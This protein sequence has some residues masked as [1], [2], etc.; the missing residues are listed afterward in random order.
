MFGKTST[1][2][3]AALVI[4]ASGCAQQSQ[5]RAA[6]DAEQTSIRCP[7]GQTLQCETRRIGRIRHGT[8]GASNENCACMPEGMATLETP[9]IP[10]IH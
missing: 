2:L 9:K 10:S 3:V 1:L 5:Q 4:A 8:F 6:R 7:H